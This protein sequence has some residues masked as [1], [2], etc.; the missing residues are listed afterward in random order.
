MI[1]P[2]TLPTWTQ[3]PDDPETPYWITKQRMKYPAA[4]V[5]VFDD[6]QIGEAIAVLDRIADRM[7]QETQQA[8]HK[9]GQALRER[10]H[11]QM[12]VDRLL[13]RLKDQA[14]EQ[15]AVAD[16]TEAA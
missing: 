8:R 15:Q 4:R 10:T 11:E 6:R 12:V 13:G 14:A 3:T 7:A 9:G 1:Y 5:L 16:D 2:R